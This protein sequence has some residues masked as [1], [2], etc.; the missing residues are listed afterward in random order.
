MGCPSQ[1][2]W[3][4]CWQEERQGGGEAKVLFREMENKEIWL[5]HIVHSENTIRIVWK[6]RMG[7][8]REERE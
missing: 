5:E 6:A 8:A 7:I 3:V 2:W 1:G 4:G